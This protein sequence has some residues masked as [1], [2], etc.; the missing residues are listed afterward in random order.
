MKIIESYLEER[1]GFVCGSACRQLVDRGASLRFRGGAKFKDIFVKGETPTSTLYNTCKAQCKLQYML[2]FGTDEATVSKQR[3]VVRNYVNACKAW[4]SRFRKNNELGKAEIMRGE[5]EEI[6]K[7]K[8]YTS[9]IPEG[10][11]IQ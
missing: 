7:H 2:K 6:M 1:G 5:L 3:R 8:F 11:N 4:M 9:L 10:G